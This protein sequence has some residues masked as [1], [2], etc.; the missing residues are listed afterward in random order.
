MNKE[1]SDVAFKNLLAIEKFGFTKEDLEKT[2]FTFRVMQEEKASLKDILKFLQ[3]TYCS[4]I[5]FEFK[6][7]I[8]KEQDPIAMKDQERH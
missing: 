2:F 7:V 5:G 3:N 8:D 1:A 4:S 6:G